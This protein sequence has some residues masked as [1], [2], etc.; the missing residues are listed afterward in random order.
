MILSASFVSG[1][2]CSFLLSL[3]TSPC[4]HRNTAALGRAVADR[5]AIRL[6]HLHGILH[7]SPSAPG[8]SAQWSG[9]LTTG[10]QVWTWTHTCSA[11]PP[12]AAYATFTPEVTATIGCIY[13]KWA[14][15]WIS[16][17]EQC[18]VSDLSNKL[19]LREA[20]LYANEEWSRRSDS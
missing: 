11:W 5:V 8:R 3:W 17:S 16:D 13:F 14:L 15:T 9:N 6:N 12:F 4:Y 2:V 10:D 20:Q 7:C 19:K 1:L 18:N